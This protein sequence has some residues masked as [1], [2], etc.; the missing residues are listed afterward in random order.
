MTQVQFESA[1]L[2]RDNG[3]MQSIFRIAFWAALAFAVTMAVLP[4]PPQLAGEM[5]DKFQHMMAFATLAVLAVLAYPGMSKIRIAL[6]LVAVG[7]GIEIVQ[8][9]PVLHRDAEWMDL[10]ADTCAILVMLAVVT[11]AFGW[12]RRTR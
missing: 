11:L 10:A 5:N 3:F 9:I 1:V 6:S 2:Q 4:H 8:M 7:A 12:H